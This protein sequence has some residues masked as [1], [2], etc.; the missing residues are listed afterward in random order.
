MNEGSLSKPSIRRA[1]ES[2]GS[3]LEEIERSCFEDCPWDAASILHHECWVAEIDGIIVG[4]MVARQL[5][6]G[7]ADLAGEREILNLAVAPA[8]RRRG[9]GLALLNHELTSAAIRFLEVRETNAAARSLYA[10][11]GFEEIGKRTD[12]YQN[13]VESAIVM[14]RK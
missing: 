1:T 2:D 13:P 7:N 10:R 4:F 9:I 14:K 6:S 8:W 12:Y 11:V 5:V 3:R